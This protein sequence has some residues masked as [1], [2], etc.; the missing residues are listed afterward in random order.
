M[1]QS[2]IHLAVGFLLAIAALPLTG[3]TLWGY[4][5]GS[6]IDEGHAVVS[7]YAPA[8]LA[9]MNEGDMYRLTRTD[10]TV[11][12]GEFEGL[13]P[14]KLS[15]SQGSKSDRDWR[16]R[17]SLMSNMLAIGDSVDVTTNDVPPQVLRGKLAG[18]STDSLWVL[19]RRSSAVFLRGI[20]LS[21]VV[22]VATTNSGT[23]K[24]QRLRELV[25]EPD[26]PR[27][28]LP[29]L[30]LKSS[31][32]EYAVPLDSIASLEKPVE[33]ITPSSGRVTW[34]LVGA[35]IDALMISA[36]ANYDLGK[37]IWTR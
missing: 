2:P 12:L 20:P 25:R 19:H 22:E 34:T 18:V 15:K 16:T 13:Q 7:E 21:D 5:I 14:V 31:G 4:L 1:R 33:W 26:S 36:A 9:E 32:K 30:V 11:L 24:G 17:D 3:C 8:Y 37:Y 10:S 35:A 6:G 27:P 23:I 29:L 28:P